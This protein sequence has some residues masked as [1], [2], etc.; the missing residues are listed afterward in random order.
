MSGGGIGGGIKISGIKCQQRNTNSYVLFLKNCVNHL[1]G[2]KKR[3]GR[4]REGR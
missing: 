3:V 4:G 1:W 2:V